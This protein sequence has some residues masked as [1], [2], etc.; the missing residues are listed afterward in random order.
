MLSILLR[1]LLGALMVLWLFRTNLIDFNVM[2][3][4]HLKIAAIAISLVLLQLFL[5]GYRVQLL[6]A[7][8]GIAVGLLRCIAFNSVGIFYSLFLPGGMSGDLARAYCFWRSYPSANKSAL[9]G[10]LFVDRLLGTVA[11]IIMG[12]IGGSLLMDTLGLTH[13]VMIAWIAFGCIAIAYLIITR[14]HRRVDKSRT[15][16]IGR[17]FRF[18]EKID[19]RGY[20]IPTIVK[21]SV[22]SIV[23]HMS[24]VAIIY[25]FSELLGSGLDFV[26]ITAIAPLGLLANALPLTPGGLGIGEK[27]FE[28][29]YSL[30]GGSHGGNSFM[31]SRI[32]LFSPALLGLLVVLI[33]FIRSHRSI[34]FLSRKG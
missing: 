24:A 11:M 22:L 34:V 5:A 14:M 25:L 20:G 30:V 2:K 19:L 18:M 32:F 7:G 26:K 6:L 21:G 33:Q 16:A 17:L 23:G 12:L 15:G 28:L 10:A 1:Y 4:V 13:F 8:H 3:A 9:F 27:G 29:L 31:T